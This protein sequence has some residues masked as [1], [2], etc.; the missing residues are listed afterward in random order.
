MS[1][2]RNILGVYGDRVIAEEVFELMLL[3]AGQSSE[4]ILFDVSP[5]FT[6]ESAG[7]LKKGLSSNNDRFRAWTVWQLRKVG[8]QFT[9]EEIDK[10]MRDESWMVRA[11]AAIAAPQLT[12]GL[13]QTDTNPFV[14][15]A[16]SLND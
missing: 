14:R 12:K 13:A 11:N 2:L 10:L 9:Q 6:I 4:S 1:P 15:F 3:N 8:Y 7:L 16:S 5:Y